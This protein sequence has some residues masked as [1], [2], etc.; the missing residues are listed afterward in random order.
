MVLAGQLAV[1]LVEV[2]VLGQIQ[3]NRAILLFVQRA[4][5][6]QFLLDLLLLAH[7]LLVLI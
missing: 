5:L 1:E 3:L 6:L 2:R 7:L 4:S